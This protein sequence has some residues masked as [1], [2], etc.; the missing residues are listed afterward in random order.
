MDLVDAFLSRMF[1]CVCQASP[2]SSRSLRS[3]SAYDPRR[4][5]ATR[6]EQEGSRLKTPRSANQGGID[7]GVCG[8]CGKLSGQ[9]LM[10]VDVMCK[11]TPQ[12]MYDRMRN[13]TSD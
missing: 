7:W 8:C 5:Q 3:G 11:Q 1:S 2:C 4:K 13:E 6:R 12:S 10:Q 9:Y